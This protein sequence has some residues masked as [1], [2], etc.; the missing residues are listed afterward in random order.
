MWT[1]F[2]GYPLAHLTEADQSALRKSP[3]FKP[4]ASTVPPG[5]CDPL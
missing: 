2:Y 3:F 4:W 1:G 5:S